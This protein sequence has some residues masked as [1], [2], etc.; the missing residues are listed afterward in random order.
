ME[1]KQIASIAKHIAEYFISDSNAFDEVYSKILHR[2]GNLPFLPTLSVKQPWAYLICSG[3]KDIE[4]RTWKC[5]KKYIGQ[6]VYIHASADKRLNLT[7]LTREQYNEA[8]EI[9]TAKG[10]VPV[11]PVDRWERS[12]IIGSVQ[13]FNCVINHPS[14]WAESS[15]IE[16]MECPKC[17]CAESEYFGD[18]EHK[19]DRCKHTWWENKNKPIYN[20]ILANPV[21][22]NEPIRDIKGKLGFWDCGKHL[23]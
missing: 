21:L 6:R 10:G 4:N 3:I 5:P 2:E 12:S 18:G 23:K 9:F 1:N 7:I 8:C 14:I 19:C 16:Q 15:I 22:F 11:K 13:I 17:G 20:W